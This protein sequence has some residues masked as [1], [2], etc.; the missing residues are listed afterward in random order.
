MKEELLCH[1]TN[2]EQGLLKDS[3]GN[4]QLSHEYAT[5]YLTLNLCKHFEPEK[6]LKII[7]L[8]SKLSFSF[9]FSLPYLIYFLLKIFNV[10]I[11]CRYPLLSFPLPLPTSSHSHLPLPWPLQYYCP[12][13]W[14]MYICSL[15]NHIILSPVIPT[16]FLFFALFSKWNTKP[17][18]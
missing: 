18:W 3:P 9:I 2:E 6:A 10:D 1:L 14:G 15:A 12:C 4:K 13:P 17:Y 16:F 11:I 7:F 8:T 5:I